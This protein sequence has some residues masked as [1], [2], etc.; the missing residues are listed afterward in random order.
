MTDVMNQGAP[1]RTAVARRAAWI[2]GIVGLALLASG[3]GDGEATGT[4]STPPAAPTTA[5]AP[6][7]SPAPSPTPALRDGCPVD[8]A[9]LFAALKA[10][11]ELFDAVNAEIS[12]VRDPACYRGY[13]TA[14]TIVPRG[15]VDPAFV[16]YEYDRDSATWK[17]INAGTHAIC[18][19]LVPRKLMFRLPGCIGS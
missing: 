7:T 5:A 12:G 3:C 10:N 16:L 17:A 4:A 1:G 8:A 9:P 19:D 14:T 13:A 15:L 11:R 2:V 6:T 18:T